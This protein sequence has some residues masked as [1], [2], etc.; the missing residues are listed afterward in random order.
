MPTRREFIIAGAAAVALSPIEKLREADKKLA[1]QRKQIRGLL[2]PG[3]TDQDAERAR[4]RQ[5]QRDKTAVGKDVLIPKLPAA[6]L[7]RRRRYEKDD[8]AWLRFYFGTKSNCADPFWYKFT[9]Q[10]REMIAAI[11]HAARWGGDQSIAASRGEGKTTIFERLAVKYGCEGLI[12][13]VVL[14]AATGTAAGNSLEAMRD[15]IETNDRLLAD[16]PEVCVPVRALE[17]TPNRAHYQTVTGFRF[18]TGEPFTRV[19]SKF[20]WCGQEVIFPNVPGSPSAGS[21]IATRGLDAAVRGLKRKGKR[22]GL[23]GIDDPDTEETARSED[24]AIKLENRIDRALGG[25]GGQQKNVARVMLTTLQTRISVS[26]K[27]T[28]PQ[29]KPTWQGKRFRFLVKPPERLDLW[30]EY[31]QMR[32]ACFQLLDDD[33]ELADPFARGA[34]KFYLENRKTMDAGAA[35]ANPHR[36]NGEKLADGS[37]L[38][39]SALQRYFNEVARIGQEA[40]SAEYDNDP[41]EESGPV[42]SGITAYRIQRQVSGYPRRVVPPDIHCV[43]Q[44]IDVGKYALHYVVKAWRADATAYVIDYGVQE[45]LNMKTTTPDSA[46]DQAILRALYSRREVLTTRPYTTADGEIVEVRKTFVDA[47]YRTKTVYHFCKE[48]G[49]SFEPA[50]GAGNMAGCAQINFRAP[51]RVSDTRRPGDGWFGALQPGGSWLIIMDKARWLGFE[52]DRWMT[53]PDMPGTCLLFGET[54]QGDRLSPDQKGHFSYSKHLTALVER[55][56][57]TKNKG[58][59]R[60]WHVK[61]DTDHYFDASYMADVAANKCGISLLKKPSKQRNGKRMSMAELAG[62]RR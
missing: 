5:K 50:M 21:V 42:E 39:V 23:V 45:V 8:A 59:I 2:H 38:E 55:E 32:H 44:G 49:L 31:V 34:H 43:T 35:V 54:G 26:Y 53:P 19:P 58:L 51:V 10:Q 6:N 17:N 29:E 18:D 46:L 16:Y 7:R 20:S 52:H 3:A 13:F 62:A 12:D 11:G 33:G 57:P 47:G 30:D 36:F 24:Q 4:Q 37:R 41:P 22:P 14:C 9:G 15:A 60:R 1:E 61:S 40:V 48:M 27:Y 25:L 56:E 28:D